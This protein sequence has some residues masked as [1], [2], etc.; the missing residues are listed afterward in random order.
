V[1]GGYDAKFQFYD[2]ARQIMSEPTAAAGVTRGLFRFA[3][4]KGADRAQM[5]SRTGLQL[6]Q[7]QDPE[8]RVPIS[9]FVELMRS[10]KELS[11]DPA[12]AL[13][14]AEEVDLSEL[15]IVGLLTHACATMREAFAQ[16]TR[17]NRLV[18]EHPSQSGERFQVMHAREGLDWLVDNRAQPN[19]FPEATEW[20]LGL[21]VC[22]PRIF[23]KTPFC[24]EVH[25]T[26]AAPSY[27]A[28]YERIF[29]AP[30][31]F[32]SDKNAL[33]IDATWHDH[34]IAPKQ[35]YAFGVLSV[36][37]QELLKKLEASKTVRSKVEG[38][39]ISVLHT[40]AVDM[41]TIAEQLGISRQSLLR[42]L[43]SEE[44]TF[45]KVLDELR[46]RLA[47]FYLEGGRVSV[48]EIAYLVGFSER[49]AFARAFKRWTGRSPGAYQSS[50]GRDAPQRA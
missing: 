38:L 14:F 34:R 1:P 27:R 2:R 12:L 36:H 6:D 26:H 29:E 41:R 50:A 4:S 15:S 17:Y 35:Q 45:E 10:A 49:A 3:I 28:E 22:G 19:A 24:R 37:A 33:L 43:K 42:K 11:K 7:L 40:G 25:V 31:F 18:W 23:D 32:E 39:L 47:L 44:T 9:R 5:E 21:L 30:I 16:I 48:N 46:R 13:H 20:A 8:A